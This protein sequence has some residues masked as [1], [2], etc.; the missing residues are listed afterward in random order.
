MNKLHLG[1]GTVYLKGYKN[2]DMDHVEARLAQAVDGIFLNKNLVTKLDD[3]YV[4]DKRLKR[5]IICDEFGR[6]RRH[7]GT[8]RN[9][10]L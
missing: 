5:I 6:H 2:I 1:C 7:Y 8:T 10:L 4:R 3:Y 9:A